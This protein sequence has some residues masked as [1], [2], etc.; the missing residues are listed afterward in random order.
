LNICA[1]TSGRNNP[2]SYLKIKDFFSFVTSSMSALQTP[3]LYR[4]GR[5]ATRRP[6]TGIDVNAG[7]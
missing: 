7:N 1:L 3:L 4:E 2:L 5:L 6:Y